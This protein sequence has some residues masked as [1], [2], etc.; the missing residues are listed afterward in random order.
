MEFPVQAIV[1]NTIK[2]GETSVMLHTYTQEFGLRSFVVKGVRTAKRN[3]KV[4][5]GMFQPLTQLEIVTLTPKHAGLSILKSAKMTQ[6]YATIPIDITKSSVCLFL[7]EVLRS[8]L[9]EEEQNYAL[10]SFL[11]NAL[12]WIDTH[13]HIANAHI[14]ILIQLTKF[15]GFY[16]DISTIEYAY[17][18]IQNGHFCAHA[19]SNECLSGN[20]IILLKTFLGTKFDA[21]ESILATSDERRA[22]LELLMRY[23]GLH[24]QSFSMPKS[25]AVLYEVFNT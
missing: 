4:S 12:A 19:N 13:D 23:Y 7:A 5:M 10:Y 2:Y 18:D 16:P 6:P 15:L 20:E 1:L 9:K 14:F 21:L 3:K 25:L 24:L 8:V 11:S 22:L 17:F